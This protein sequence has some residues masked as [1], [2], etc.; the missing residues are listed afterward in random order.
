MNAMV[1]E[2]IR[3]GQ[4]A[5]RA[6]LHIGRTG[7]TSFL[8]KARE[9]A[10]SEPHRVPILFPSGWTI[11]EIL[12]VLPHARISFVVRDP[13]NRIISAFM[14]RARAGRSDP[15][16][17]WSADEA[18]AFLLFEDVRQY[19]RALISSNAS[20]AASAERASLAIDDIR[21]DYQLHFPNLTNMGQWAG[22][23][24]RL[25][26]L[27]YFATEVLGPGIEVDWMHLNPISPGAIVTDLSTREVVR[28]RQHF[29]AEYR[30]YETLLETADHH[31]AAA[32]AWRSTTG[33]RWQRHDTSY[34]KIS[35][36]LGKYVA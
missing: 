10:I 19:L 24:R 33:H 23:I 14:S 28:L 13:L 17:P 32:L 3:R 11:P 9:L 30:V 27:R 15:G 2:Q 31:E 26:D 29:A 8:H 18:A 1:D 4:D 21:R 12:K 6:Y 22:T 5:S 35:P 25:D 34:G 7:G 16:I 20:E 36:T